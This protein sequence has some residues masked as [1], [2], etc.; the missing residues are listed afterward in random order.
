MAKFFGLDIPLSLIERSSGEL[1]ISLWKMSLD[2]SLRSPWFGYGWGR[3]NAGYFQVYENYKHIFQNIYFEKSHNLIFDLALWAGW[4][5]SIAFTLIGYFWLIQSLRSVDALDRLLVLMAV[6]AFLIHAM[7]E[8][9]LHYGY[10]LWPFFMLAGSIS[11]NSKSDRTPLIKIAPTYAYGALIT[12][13]IFTAVVTID[14]FKIE[15]SF[16]DLR[17]RVAKVGTQQEKENVD[18]FI[19]RDWPEVIALS[20]ATPHSGMSEAQITH[21]EALLLYNTAPLNLRKIIGANK[22]NGKD[23]RARMWANSGCWLLPEKAC[24]NLFDEWPLPT[25][26]EAQLNHPNTVTQ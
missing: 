26:T 8:F 7:L 16:T 10:F 22:L 1:R 14:Y 18:L 20:N 25:P 15:E 21:W 5:T 17:F 11:Q 19:L 2:A 13:I 23:A 6:I 12:L 3:S 24:V 4:P 9:P